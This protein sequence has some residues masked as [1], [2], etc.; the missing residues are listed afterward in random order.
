MVRAHVRQSNFHVVFVLIT[1]H[2]ACT[3]TVVL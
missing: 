3:C 1:L 2:T